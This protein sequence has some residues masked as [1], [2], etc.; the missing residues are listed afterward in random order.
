L[1]NPVLDRA[2]EGDLKFRQTKGEK[3][4]DA[5]ESA[6]SKTQQ[7]RKQGAML[8]RAKMMDN[9]ADNGGDEADKI[10]AG[11]GYRRHDD[12]D[13]TTSKNDINEHENVYIRNYV[14]TKEAKRVHS[15]MNDQVFC[16]NLYFYLYKYVYGLQEVDTVYA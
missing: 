12:D 8:K 5:T 2:F 4:D 15:V 1:L 16:V 14:A 13:V 6:D 11:R 9:S 10:A 3:T 7:E